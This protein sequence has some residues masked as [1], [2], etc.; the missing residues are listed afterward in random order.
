MSQTGG[1]NF[2]IASNR[3]LSFSLL[4]TGGGSVVL[5]TSGSIKATGF[6]AGSVSFRAGGSVVLNGFFASASG[7]AVFGFVDELGRWICSGRDWLRP[8]R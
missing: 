4:N 2:Q 3:D 7:T 6:S 5:D 8:V 1:G